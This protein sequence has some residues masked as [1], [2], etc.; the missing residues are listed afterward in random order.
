MEGIAL[1]TALL[2]HCKGVVDEKYRNLLALDKAA[3]SSAN[4]ETKSSAGDKYETGRAMMHLEKERLASQMHEVAKLKKP[5][6][7]INP[8]KIAE[9][10]E[11][12]SVVFT[13][14]RNY[15]IS[16]SL[17]AIS[18][19]GQKFFCISPVT[20][21]GKLMLGKASGESFQFAGKAVRIQEIW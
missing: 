15:Y 13:Q 14:D 21:I 10:A 20:P 12:G 18:I 11:L 19:E 4:N 9:V 5:L 6:E 17:G 3:Q 16:V 2:N 7:M 1:K 8:E